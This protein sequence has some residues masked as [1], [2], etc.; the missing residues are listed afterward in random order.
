MDSVKRSAVTPSKSRLARTFAKVFHIQAVTVK[1]P[2]DKNQK[3][4]SYEKTNKDENDELHDKAVKEAFLAKLFASISTVKA[5]YAHLQ[6]AQSPYDADGIQSADQILVSELKNLSELKQSFLKKQMNDTSPETTLFLSEIQ[7]Q[8]SLLETYGITTK[9]LDSQLKLKES[10]VIFLEEKLVEVNKENKSLEKRLNSSGQ[11]AMPDNTQLSS[12]TPSHFIAYSRH[13]IKSI[14]SFVR[15]LISEM[16]NA[17]WDLNVAAKSIQPGISFWKPNHICFAFESFVCKEMFDGFNH[18]EFSTPKTELPT[19]EEKRARA[20]LFFDRFLELKSVGAA[21]YLAWKPKSK[22]ATFCRKKYLRLV[23]P[24]MEASIF[25]NLNQRNLVDSGELPETPFFL[26][27]SEM[28][29]RLWLLHCLALSFDPEVSFF[30]V[31]KGNRFSE[32][33]MESLSDEAFEATRESDPRVG[34]VVV[35][36]FSIGRTVIQCQVYLC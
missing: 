36:G 23:H 13:A 1:P 7:E 28:A 4:N 31:K 30:Q 6:F 17:D 19:E 2:D 21:D 22:F 32:V 12:L 24:K 20:R 15:L 29:K 8:K 9:K 14:R 5:A 25:G 27:F 18:P 33:Y 35:P 34:F 16:E 11:L 3:K 10:E 26:A